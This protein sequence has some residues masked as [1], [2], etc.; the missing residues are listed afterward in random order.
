M[1]KQIYL[2]AVIQFYFRDY[3]SCNENIKILAS[4]IKV[5]I[6]FSLKRINQLIIITQSM[7]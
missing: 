6:Y 7:S 2:L 3:D 4:D 5:N 1:E